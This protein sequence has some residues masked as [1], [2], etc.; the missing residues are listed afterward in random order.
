MHLSVHGVPAADL[1]RWRPLPDQSER[2][3]ASPAQPADEPRRDE[4]SGD[5]PERSVE[6]VEG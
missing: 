6:A 5:E 1:Y 4:L 3:E 2:C